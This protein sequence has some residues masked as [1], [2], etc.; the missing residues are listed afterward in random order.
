MNADWSKML[1]PSAGWRPSLLRELEVT[2]AAAA[3]PAERHEPAFL[4]ELAVAPPLKKWPLLLA[5]VAEQAGK[6]LGLDPAGLDSRQGL[7]DLGLDSLMALELR[8]RLQ[9]TAGASLRSTLAFDYPTIDAIARHLA[10]DVLE[11][12]LESAAHPAAEPP[13]PA[14]SADTSDLL[15][16]IENLS[17]EEVE[18]LFALRTAGPGA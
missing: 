12:E 5:H 14:E 16:E 10:A 9:R 1:A 18:K 2:T 7:R 17:D 11:I 13:V 6:V 3:A 4:Q 15:M 8:N